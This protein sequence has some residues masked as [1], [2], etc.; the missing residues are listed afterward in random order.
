MRLDRASRAHPEDR[1]N[2]KQELCNFITKFHV[3]DQSVENICNLNFNHLSYKIFTAMTFLQPDTPIPRKYMNDFLTTIRHEHPVCHQKFS[4]LPTRNS[5]DSYQ[6]DMFKDSP[7]MTRA[8][9]LKFCNKCPEKQYITSFLPN[10]VV[11]HTNGT[12]LLNSNRILIG[13]RCG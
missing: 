12:V 13:A 3:V 9:V 8:S 2:A 7:T 10:R 1:I 11:R 4:V 5:S 6:V